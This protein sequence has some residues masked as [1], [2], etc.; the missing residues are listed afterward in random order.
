MPASTT[1]WM[2]HLGS[3]DPR[4]VKGSLSIAEDAV[5]FETEETTVS[6]PWTVIR[7]AKRLRG[8]PVLMVEWSEDGQARRTAFY[9]TKPPPLEPD[10]PLEDPMATRGA[11]A[12]M[13]RPSKRRHQRQN[14][15]YLQTV[16]IDRKSQIQG[17]ADEITRRISS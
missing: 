15:R 3:G 13:R 16:G 2:V 14:I 6:I 5:A 11:F 1:V 7:R 4:D 12:A 10:D 9:F 17:W 8:S